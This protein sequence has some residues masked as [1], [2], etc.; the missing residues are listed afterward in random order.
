MRVIYKI[1]NVINNKFYVGSAVKFNKRRA[2]HL[3]QLK[4][5]SHTNKHLQAAW[6]QYGE[7]S[8]VFAVVEEVPDDVSILEVEN[9]WLAEHVGKEYCYNIALD[10]TAP[11]AGRTGETSPRWGVQ[12]PHTEETKRKI[13]IASKGRTYT[14]EVNKRKTAHLHGKPKSAEIRAKISKTLSGAGNPNYGKPR[15]DEFKE[16]VSRKVVMIAPDG[17]KHTYPSILALREAT[18]LK[19][20]TVNNALKHGKAMR[21]GSYKGWRIT[22]EQNSF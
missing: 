5:G 12:I 20:S 13:G 19:P 22:D 8:F 1:I 15:S 6:N 21:A 3:R 18:G 14:D 4:A 17:E 16:K 10:A 9:K 2:T 11:M 7:K